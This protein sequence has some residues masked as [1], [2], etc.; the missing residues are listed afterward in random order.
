[1]T[2]RWPLYLATTIVLGA[3]G[4]LL[5]GALHAWLIEPIWRRLVGGLPFALLAAASMVWCYAE[6]ARRR[7]VPAGVGGGVLFGAGLWLALLPMTAVAA[8]LRVSGARATLGS[9]E[10][11]IELVAGALTGALIGFAMSRSWRLTLACTACVTA[12]VVAMAG[13]IAVP[14]GPTQR[15]LLLGFLP[16]YVVAGA[17]LSL[18]LRRRASPALD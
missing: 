14:V 3:G 17:A 12:V 8:V 2:S 7:M 18:A 9:V 4:T 13:P 5:F 15:R 11:A 6:F 1:M 16:L 10:P